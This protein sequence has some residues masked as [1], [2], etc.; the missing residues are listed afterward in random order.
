M[1]FEG[2]RDSGSYEAQSG[3]V[4]VVRMDRHGFTHAMSRVIKGEVVGEAESLLRERAR[5]GQRS[6]R[7]ELGSEVPTL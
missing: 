6:R 3:A 4:S 7:T 5:S 2:K 1:T